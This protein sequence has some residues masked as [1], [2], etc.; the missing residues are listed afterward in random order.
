ML[1]ATKKIT[2]VIPQNKISDHWKEKVVTAYSLKIM[3][4][5][6]QILLP[7]LVICSVMVLA[8]FVFNNFLSLALS[9]VGAA[10]S[11]IIGFGYVY[12]RQKFIR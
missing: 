9:L 4:Y 2:Y 5:S 10:E 1:K 6:L 8:D 7:L 3:K 11:V 12:L